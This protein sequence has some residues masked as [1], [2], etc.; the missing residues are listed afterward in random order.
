MQPN[1]MQVSTHA[2]QETSLEWPAAQEASQLKVF[3]I[4]SLHFITV[5][6]AVQS[7]GTWTDKVPGTFFKCMFFSL[8]ARGGA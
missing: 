2:W 7:E 5:S 3:P 1:L 8:T 6:F 4:P